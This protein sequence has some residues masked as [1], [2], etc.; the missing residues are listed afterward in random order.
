MSTSAAFSVSFFEEDGIWAV[1]PEGASLSLS[2]VLHG[3][4]VFVSGKL[5]DPTFA[6]KV[7]GRYVPFAAAIAKGFARGERGSGKKK[8]PI[9]ERKRGGIVLGVLLLDVSENDLQKLDAFEQVPELRERVSIR[10]TVGARERPAYTF[11]LKR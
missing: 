3:D 10:V 8:M 11:L 6:Y 7:T 4:A 2:E 1:H 5:M 9:L